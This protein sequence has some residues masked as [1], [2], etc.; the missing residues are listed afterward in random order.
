MTVSGLLQV[1][2]EAADIMGQQQALIDHRA[3]GEG[4][5]CKAAVMAGSLC[6]LARSLQR[7]LGLLADGQQLA[8]ERVLVLGVRA[9]GHDRLADQRHAVQHGL[10][11][12]GGI[13]RHVAP[14]Q[15][16]LALDL[17]EMLELLDHDLARLGFARQ[18][19]HGHGIVAGRRQG[20]AGLLG[21]V[22]E[23]RDRES[24]SGCRRRRP[25]A[26]RRPPRRDGPD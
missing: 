18:E 3:G 9:R 10:A 23:Q 26:D 15:Q 11:Q 2:V 19:A 24:G 6:F 12:A 5:A 4:W 1:A 22:A 21:P 25:P 8:L 13:G 14:A 7:V 16:L 17:D 20:D